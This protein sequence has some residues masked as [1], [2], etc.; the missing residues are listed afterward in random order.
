MEKWIVMIVVGMALVYLLQRV[1]ATFSAS[2]GG[3][4]GCGCSGCGTASSCDARGEAGQPV[5]CPERPEDQ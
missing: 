5:K 1:R 4:C 3:A 2:S